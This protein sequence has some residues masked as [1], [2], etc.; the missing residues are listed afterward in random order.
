M[1]I[2]SGN[3]AQTAVSRTIPRTWGDTM[4]NAL[5]LFGG[6]SSEHAVSCWSAASVI[7]NIPRDKYAVY[8]LGITQDGE[9]LLYEGDTETLA[10]DKWADSAYCTKAILSPDR[11]DHGVLVFR[12]TGTQLIK[13]DV[14]FPVLHGKNGE[15]GT[16]QGLLELAGIPYVGCGTPS[17]AMCMDKAVTNLVADSAGVAQAKWLSVTAHEYEKDMSAFIARAEEYLGLPLFVK[18]ANAGSSVGISK[19]KTHEEFFA[20]METAFREDTKVVA[21]EAIDA[22]EAECAVLGNQEPMASVVGGIVPC[23]EFYTYE[24]KYIDEGS[25]LQIPAKVSAEAQD[26][27]RSAAVR[28]YSALGCQGLARADFFVEKGTGRVLFNEINTLPG[29]TAISMY[30]KLMEQSG[31]PYPKLL[32]KLFKLAQEK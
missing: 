10:Q 24:A 5:I 23:E 25:E 22:L 7:D 9:W 18:P 1:Y 16:M 13:I 12:E 4:I 31:V 30:P 8:M 21:E 26:A 27:V 15:D 19:V 6:V 11:Q 32:D 28:I 14:A 20:A 29:F 2:S 17:S 3:A